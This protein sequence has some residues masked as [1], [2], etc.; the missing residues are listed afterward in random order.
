MLQQVVK[1]PPQIVPSNVASRARHANSLNSEVTHV[2]INDKL[3][4]LEQWSN[5]CQMSR[6]QVISD[7]IGLVAEGHIQVSWWIVTPEKHRWN[8][9]VTVA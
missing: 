8:W 9:L 2:S 5:D 3:I 7:I 6:S 4:S 1:M